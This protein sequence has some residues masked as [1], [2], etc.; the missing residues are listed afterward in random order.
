MERQVFRRRHLSCSMYSLS[1]AFVAL[2]RR[3]KLSFASF[4]SCLSR[5]QMSPP[6]KRQLAD[7]GDDDMALLSPSTALVR[8]SRESSGNH[9]GEARMAKTRQVGLTDRTPSK[10]LFST[11][12]T[13]R[14]ALSF[15]CS[16]PSSQLQ[17]SAR[18]RVQMTI[19]IALPGTCT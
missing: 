17:L 7:D 1:H 4:S 11:E 5:Q 9:P 16:S 10:R 8:R 2:R 15:F 13:S 19:E 12:T 18:D 6:Q 14:R 3:Q